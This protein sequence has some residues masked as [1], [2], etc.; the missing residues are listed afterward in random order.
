[1]SKSIIN[2]IALSKDYWLDDF[3]CPCCQTVKLDARVVAM[4]QQIT[5]LT[6]KRIVPNSAYRCP[7]HNK[8]VGGS[9]TSQHMDG[10]CVD[11]TIPKGYNDIDF[12]AI[13]EQAGARRVG[14]Y[15]DRWFLHL[16]VEDAYR[17][18][19]RLSKRFYL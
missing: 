8:E 16:S 1:M 4:M 3:Q 5:N 18:G 6:D 12:A 2:K 11:I 9:P 7:K 13:C 10:F 19:K 14:V 15:K 17:N